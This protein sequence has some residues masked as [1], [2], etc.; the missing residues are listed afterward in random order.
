MTQTMKRLLLIFILYIIVFDAYSQK[1]DKGLEYIGATTSFISY[2]GKINTIKKDGNKTYK[3]WIYS[4]PQM[5]HENE[6]K[7]RMIK[8]NNNTQYGDFAYS[9]ALYYVECGKDNIG[10]KSTIDY[11]KNGEIIFNHEYYLPN[12][13]TVVPDTMG[14][15]IY[16]YVCKYVN[17]NKFK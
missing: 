16:E 2:Y 11:A 10:L 8:D 13:S 9:I 7:E 1:L 5:G 17:E 3:I 15:T 4:Y 6:C 12:Y 14:E